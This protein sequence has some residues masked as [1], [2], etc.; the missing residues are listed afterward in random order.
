MLMIYGLGK[1]GAPYQTMLMDPIGG[2]VGA[3]SWKDGVNTGGFIHSPNARMVDVELN[4]LL[5]PIMYLFRREAKDSGGPGEYR[6]G[7]TLELAIVPHD[8]ERIAYQTLAC[9]VT[10][11]NNV[12]LAGGL[13]GAPI[14][15][16]LLQ[17]TEI[18]SHLAGGTVPQEATVEALGGELV[19][20]S[21]RGH[22]EQDADSIVYARATSSGGFGDPLARDPEKVAQ[23]VVD[24]YVSTTVAELIYGAIVDTDGNLDAT[25]TTARRDRV[26][27]ARLS[28]GSI[29]RGKAGGMLDESASKLGQINPV[30]GIYSAGGRQVIACTK[31]RTELANQGDNYKDGCRE[32]VVEL[33]SLPYVPDPHRYEMDTYLELRRYCCPGCGAQLAADLAEPGEPPF[34]DVHVKVA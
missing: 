33:D 20:P 23:D 26:L 11:P 7:A 30:I 4:E 32:H 19:W 6:G 27:A 8:T 22:F 9:G 3:R 24:G 15:Y 25:A 2:C 17:G 18:Q 10:F 29:P 21:F 31:C 34:A 13:P 16:R 28:E 1:D 5:Y 14:E 12:G